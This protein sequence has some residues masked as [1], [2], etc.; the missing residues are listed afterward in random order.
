[1]I[2]ISEL[3]VIKV[4]LNA[5]FLFGHLLNDAWHPFLIRHSEVVHQPREEQEQ[6]HT[7]PQEDQEVVQYSACASGYRHTTFFELEK[8][9]QN[10]NAE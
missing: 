7:T 5:Q 10:I 8:K 3:I 6:Y 2:K 9:A 4:G 1:V